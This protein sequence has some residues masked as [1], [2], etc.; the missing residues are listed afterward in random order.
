MYFIFTEHV[1]Q[2]HYTTCEAHLHITI[3]Y[4]LFNFVE[5]NNEKRIK[6]LEDEH[7]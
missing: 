2:F 3:D 1:R 7:F 5:N 4:L 6:Q